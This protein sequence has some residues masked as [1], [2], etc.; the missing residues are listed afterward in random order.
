MTKL[1]TIFAIAVAAIATLSLAAPVQADS[2][3]LHKIGNAIQ[4]P[5]RKA[6][7]NI[8]VGV[9]RDEHK[10]SVETN[11]GE[12]L[13]EVVTPNGTR[14]VKGTTSGRHRH[15]HHRRHVAK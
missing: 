1:K 15:R 10:K 3:T 4:Y 6:G 14:Y 2:N 13:K 5:V 12:H 7:E 11:R 8:S 9:H